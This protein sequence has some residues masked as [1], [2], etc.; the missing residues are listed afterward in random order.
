LNQ[1]KTE[2]MTKKNLYQRL[3]PKL[4]STLKKELK[5]Y[6]LILADLKVTLKNSFDE[7]EITYRTF[8]TMRIYLNPDFHYTHQ[9]FNK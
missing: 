9:Y 6:P 3:K 8:S 2:T 5:E 7:Q 4:K 1:F